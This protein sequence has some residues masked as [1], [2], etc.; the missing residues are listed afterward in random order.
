MECCNFAV[1][2]TETNWNDEVMSI[3]IVAA[4]ARSKEK[5]IRSTISFHQN[6]RWEG[7]IRQSLD[8][9][10]MESVWQAESRH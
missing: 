7:Y 9:V 6:I 8:F 1:I 3:G 10:N 4:D 2:D 5:S